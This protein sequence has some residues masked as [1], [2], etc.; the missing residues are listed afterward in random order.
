MHTVSIGTKQVSPVK[1]KISGL[2]YKLFFLN[3]GIRSKYVNILIK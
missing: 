1:H 2:F 3:I